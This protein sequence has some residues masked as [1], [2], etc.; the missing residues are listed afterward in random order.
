[1]PRIGCRRRL[2]LRVVGLDPLVSGNLKEF[3]IGTHEERVGA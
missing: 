2:Q 1:M 3:D